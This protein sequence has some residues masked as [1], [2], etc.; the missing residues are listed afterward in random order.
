MMKSGSETCRYVNE[1]ACI[2]GTGAQRGQT[3]LCFNPSAWPR[4]SAA[5]RAEITDCPF[6]GLKVWTGRT[7]NPSKAING[8]TGSAESPVSLADPPLSAPGL[9]NTSEP[10][11]GQSRRR[12][13]PDRSDGILIPTEPLSSHSPPGIHLQN[14]T[15][16]R[17][18]SPP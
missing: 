16:T 14:P 11:G 10:P 8:S 2:Y 3:E 6:N 5:G 17:T 4:P 1:P 15:R 7:T 12:P 18:S 13:G 9:G